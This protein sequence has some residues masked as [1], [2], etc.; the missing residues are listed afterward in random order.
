MD[1][2]LIVLIGKEVAYNTAFF[3]F[4]VFGNTMELDNFNDNSKT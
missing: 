3:I 2:E 1:R 4:I